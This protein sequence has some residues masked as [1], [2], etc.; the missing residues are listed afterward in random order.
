MASSGKNTAGNLY[1][2]SLTAYGV[3]YD[4]ASNVISSTAAG[5]A[6][7]LIQSSGAGVAPAYTTATYPATTTVSQILYS[8]ATNVVSGLATANNGLLITSNTGVPSLLANGTPG[9]VVTAQ[10]G[11]PPAWAA[12]SSE[13][14]WTPTD[15]SGAGLTFS[16][17]TGSYIRIGTLVI[18]TCIVIYPA[19][20][21]A[22]AAI[23]G[24][25]P[26]TPV[27]GN[28]YR[29]GTVTYTSVGTLARALTTSGTAQFQLYTATATNVT[30]ATMTLSTN[31]FQIIYQTA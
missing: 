19:T 8:S 2:T 18:A 25:L 21:D 4:D 28:Q 20:A 1:Q 7:Q 5:T 11:A 12:I 27:T 22:S 26:F 15:A 24:G 3:L 10:S 14:A 13:A 17:A 31:F 9:Y 6:G 16:T 30:N 29:A 23:I